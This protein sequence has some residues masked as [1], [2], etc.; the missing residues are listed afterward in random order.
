MRRPLAIAVAVLLVAVGAAAGAAT[1]TRFS[2]VSE[3]HW[4][5]E[6]IEWAAEAGIVVGK[7]DGTFDPTGELNRA[8]MV[9]ILYRYHQTFGEVPYHTHTIPDHTH[10]G[11]SGSY[12]CRLDLGPAY[13]RVLGGPE[14]ERAEPG[15]SGWHRHRIDL[16]DLLSNVTVEC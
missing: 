14:T 3:D 1:A 8:Q 6:A 4:A 2:D 7:G 15:F 16:D 5:A 13:T 10:P 11:G 12:S 9:A